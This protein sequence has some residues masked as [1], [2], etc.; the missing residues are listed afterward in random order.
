MASEDFQLRQYSAPDFNDR[1]FT[2][3]PLAQFEPAP[4]DGVAPENYHGTSIFPEYYKV[5]Q[6][7]WLIPKR[8]R[9]DCVAVLDNNEINVIEMRRLK[10]GDQVAIGRKEHGEE[11]IFVHDLAFSGASKMQD[12]FA[13]RQGFSRETSFSIDYDQ[14]YKLLNY[15]KE[16]GFIVW[17]MGPAVVFDHDARTALVHIIKKGY[18]H[19]VLAGNALATHDIEASLFGTALGTGL[20]KK[21]SASLGHYHHLDALN[22]VRRAGSIEAAIEQGLIAD[23]AMYELIQNKVPYVLAGSI[24]DDGPLPEVYGDVYQAQDEMRKVIEQAT[25]V[26]TIATQLHSI[27]TGNMVP[28][29]TFDRENNVRPVYLYTVDMSEF[30]VNKLSD[31][32]SLLA[33]PILT[34]AQDFLVHLEQKLN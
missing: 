5:A 8:T 34:N 11:G 20:Y 16:N 19:A 13:F 32:G 7:T 3:A 26:I 33:V 27:A 28:S 25:T 18:V 31:R 15:E 17:V 6:D 12:K 1:V 14:L 21:Q 9:M 29:Y 24:R 30:V 10:K 2:Q 22:K 4:V 23:G